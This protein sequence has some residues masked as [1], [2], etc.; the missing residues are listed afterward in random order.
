MYKRFQAIVVLI[1]FVSICSAQESFILVSKKFDLKFYPTKP[2][3]SISIT[4]RKIET[5]HT[6]EFTYVTLSEYITKEYIQCVDSVILTLTSN[7]K[8][9][10]NDL[11]SDSIY[12]QYDGS[13]VCRVNYYISEAQ[14]HELGTKYVTE[15]SLPHNGKRLVLFLEE[16]SRSKILNAIALL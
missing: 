11:I 5:R 10:F 15:I 6:I 1:L 7:R 4:L 9:V 12:F 8:L 16:R 14:I 2:V 13:I 3:S